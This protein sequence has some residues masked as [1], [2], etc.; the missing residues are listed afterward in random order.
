MLVANQTFYAHPRITNPT[1]VDL[2][3]YWWTCVAVDAKPSTRIYTPA[4]HVA[5]TSRDPM[6]NA[7][8]PWFAEAIENASFAGY[9]NAWMTDN[10]YLGNHQIGDMFLRIP[11][12]CLLYTSPSPRDSTSS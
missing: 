9:Q 12:T 3:G 11:D 5:E 1:E 8:W 7:P 4:T 6:R 2:R 10:S